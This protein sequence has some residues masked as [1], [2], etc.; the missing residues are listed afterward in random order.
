MQR[1]TTA[2]R[3]AQLQFH[4]FYKQIF[5]WNLLKCLMMVSPHMTY[6]VT[7]FILDK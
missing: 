4:I 2:E 1:I 7:F 3:N 5:Q 6:T